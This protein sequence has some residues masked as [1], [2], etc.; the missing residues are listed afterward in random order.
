MKLKK[1]N[2]LSYFSEM[3]DPRVDRTRYH[4]LNDIIFI[5]IAAVLSGAESWNEIEYYGEMKED[6]LRTVLELPNG[7]PSHDTFNRLFSALDPNEFERC[8]LNWVKSVN[9]S[10]KGEVVS[11]DGK[12]IRGSK[13]LGFKT[14]THIVSAW[15][16]KNELILGQVKVDEKSNEITAIPQLLD[17]LLVTGCVVTIDAMGCQKKIARKIVSKKADYILAVKENQKELFDDIQDSFRVLKPVDIDEDIDYGH[18]RIETRK[19]SVLTD[20]GLVDDHQEW[21]GLASIIRIERERYFKATG[22]KETES[23]YYISTLTDAPAINKGVRKH[24]GIENKVHWVLDVA[25]NEDHSRKRAGNA[26][27]NFSTLN[28]VALNLLK[29]DDAKL[30]I[31]GKRKIIGWNNDYIFKVLKN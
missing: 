11:I 12:T 18:G 30:G 31:K 5:A 1:T 27:Q 13:K 19:C 21:K 22:K 29:K 28:R 16:D 2:L 4:N 3:K 14:A 25:F 6:W 10:T 9:E 17:S 8:F 24:W 26:A 15:A 23:S 20:F 7:I